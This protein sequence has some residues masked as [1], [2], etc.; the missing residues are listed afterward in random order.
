MDDSYL[1]RRSLWHLVQVASYLLNFCLP[2]HDVLLGCVISKNAMLAD[3]LL[4]P[5]VLH[6]HC[7][8]QPTE[9]FDEVDEEVSAPPAI[10]SP[11][12]SAMTPAASISISGELNHRPSLPRPV[13]ELGKE[14]GLPF[15]PISI[16]FQRET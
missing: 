8:F 6:S 16:Y 10:Y 7:H 12:T 2:S 15:L 9:M 1:L 14:E 5:P 4:L 11:R 3:R 13:D